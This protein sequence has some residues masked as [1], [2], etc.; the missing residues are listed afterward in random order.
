MIPIRTIHLLFLTAFLVYGCNQQHKLPISENEEIVKVAK[1][2][3]FTEGPTA[4]HLGNIYFTDQPNN[5]IYKYGVDGELLIFTDSAGR[6]NGLYIDQNQKLWACADGENQ[7]WKFSL[8][9]QREVVLNP[10]GE[11]KFNGPNDV[12]VHQ[13]GNLYFTDPIYQRPYWENKHDTVG[14][15]SIYLLKDGKPILLDSTLVQANGVVG[16]S[17]KKLLFVADIGADK[18][19]RYAIDE[20]GMLQDKTL[21]VAQGS[22]GM[23]IDSNGNLY[24]TGKGVDVFDENGNFLQHLDIPENWTANVSFGGSNFDQLYITASKSL[25][26]VKTKVKAVR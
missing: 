20:E 23:T 3:A 11:V 1:G 5:L 15:Q 14:H 21:F 12:W 22:D 8:D 19:Y 10:S 4:D 18:T 25:Y 6:A 2:F 24:L 16:H 17:E 13:N 26:R 9:G 7:L